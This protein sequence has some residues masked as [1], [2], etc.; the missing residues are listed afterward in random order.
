MRRT[1]HTLLSQK[2][3]LQENKQL[4]CFL[5]MFDD[6]EEVKVVEGEVSF[7][8]TSSYLF[9]VCTKNTHNRGVQ[10]QPH[11]MGIVIFTVRGKHG[12]DCPHHLS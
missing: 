4:E 6:E 12:Y 5:L 11:Q 9:L 8:K 1:N 7:E 3:V 10:V 2:R